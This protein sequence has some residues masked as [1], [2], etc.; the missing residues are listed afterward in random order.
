MYILNVIV[1]VCVF[2]CTAMFLLSLSVSVCVYVRNVRLYY[3]NLRED[4][5]VDTRVCVL[6]IELVIVDLH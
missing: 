6:E 4:R 2:V 5:F 3:N 1:C